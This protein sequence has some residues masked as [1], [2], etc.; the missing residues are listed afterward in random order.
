MSTQAKK[1]KKKKKIPR[2]AFVKCRGGERAPRSFFYP[3]DIKD[4]TQAVEKL[5]SN[6][7]CK[8]GC[9]GMGTCTRV[10]R[11]E[12]I[13]MGENG[14]PVIDQEKC[15]GCG[16]CVRTCPQNVLELTSALS[17][18]FRFNRG[19]DCLAPCQQ[20]CPAQIDIPRFIKAIEV[21]DFT[22]ALMIIKEHMPMPLTLGRVCPRPCEDSCRRQQ[23]DEAVA[24]NYLKR[25]V[26]D[27]EWKSKKRVP[28]YVAPDTGHKVAIIGG[29]PGGLSCAYFLR[30][31]GHSVKIF[32]SMP[33]LGG[34]LRYGIPDYRLPPEILDWEIEGILD[35]GIEVETE[36]ALGR[37]F[38]LQDLK[39]RGYEAIF[40][41]TGA[42]KTW[43]PRMEGNDARGVMS[44]VEFLRKVAEGNPPSLGKRVM[45]VGGGNVAMDAARTA[46]RLGAEDVC[47]IYRRSR[48]EM[49]ALEEEIEAAEAEGIKFLFLTNP[50][51]CV[52]CERGSL[53][54]VECIHME[55]GEPDASGRR[56]PQPKEGSEFC[57]QA[58]NLILAIGQYPDTEIFKEDPLG[59][60]LEITKWDT[61]TVDPATCQ[62]IIPGV[63]AGGDLVIGPMRV[64]D[65][66]GMGRLAARSIDMY[67]REGIVKPVEKMLHNPFPEI[68]VEKNI[69]KAKRQSMPHLEVKERVTNFA[70]VE[71]GYDE[72]AALAEAK[73]CLDCGLQ[74]Y[75]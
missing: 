14:V 74:C 12:A 22:R 37:D 30:R 38:T 26:A 48:Q 56:R 72:D 10:C 7:V 60:G 28:L 43:A 17:M 59:K 65:A 70:E 63:F 52:K 71:L 31:F 5:G 6:L 68:K 2:W 58:D 4:C 44:G 21:G 53:R 29:G 9:L 42:W 55:L 27:L 34:M 54:E 20:A 8:I 36:V 64:V 45:I 23:V 39:D 61:I 18:L 41:A 47:V 62:T 69:E 75:G 19:D 16:K 25:F 32:E 15:T 66:I 40:L 3:D 35:L 67:L 57:L 1:N 73:R 11:F 51:R 46:L 24:I 50:V 33:R 49:P 13:S